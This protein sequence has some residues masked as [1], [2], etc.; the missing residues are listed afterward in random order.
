MSSTV[1]RYR[2]PD[3]D[4]ARV[5]DIPMARLRVRFHMMPRFRVPLPPIRATPSSRYAAVRND[6]P[7]TT[8]T[9]SRQC[10]AASR[11]TRDTPI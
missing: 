9:P 1:S 10:N 5:D 7:I 6:A 8:S 3:A 11:F 4:A 2:G